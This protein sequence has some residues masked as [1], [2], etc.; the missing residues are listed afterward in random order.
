MAAR[1]KLATTR[2][3]TGGLN[4]RAD[5]FL[6][7]ANESPDLLNVDIDPRGGFR[8]RKGAAAFGS[9][10]SGV[11]RSLWEYT[12]GSIGSQ[13][14][15][16]H[17]GITVLYS[18]GGGWTPVCTMGGTV[19]AATFKDSCYLANG[20]DAFRWDGA[21]ATALG[22]AWNDTEN[23]STGNM[24]RGKCV[25]SHMGLMFVAN[26][27]EAGVA[28]PNRL[29]W[30]MPNFPESYRSYD[31]IDIDIGADG[32]EITALVPWT[33]HLLVFK[34]RAVYALYG[35][36]PETFQ[37]MPVTRELGAVSQE[38][39]V[40]TD[41][42]VYF[43]S[44]PDGVF[45][46]VQGN[47][48]YV[49][50]RIYPAIQDGSIPHSAQAEIMLGWGHRRLWVGVPWRSETRNRSFVLDPAVGKTGAWTTYDL[51]AGP[52]LEYNPPGADSIFL[53]GD[54]ANSQGV[55]R[56]DVDASADDFNGT[57]VP[58]ITRYRTAWMDGGEPALPKRFT[59]PEVILK[60]GND[61]AVFVN[62]YWDW[63]PLDARRQFTLS[64]VAPPD[65]VA[66]PGGDEGTD[67][68]TVGWD[69]SDWDDFSWAEGGASWSDGGGGGAN[70]GYTVPE[71]NELH[72]GRALGKCRAVALEFR[73]PETT[74][75]W[76]VDSITYK[77][78]PR[79]PRS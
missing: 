43:F 15:M 19:R 5:G 3:F 72:R 44:W 16:A 33:D 32:D 2:D 74:Q 49:F 8:Q 58:I 21:T 30:S 22:E 38:A 70:G 56:L 31:Y 9:G 37:V 77:F 71:K 53:A 73:G 17:N 66:D 46:Y 34:K 6:L 26:T 54:S 12:N 40:A 36:S 64:T 55:I 59:R 18:T 28:K 60:S 45:Q 25:A 29:R 23:A 75:D 47:P 52:F 20:L 63:N 67:A 10:F 24:P 13:M 51:A 14:V 39:V 69:L 35:Y 41:I 76:G 65:D 7:A 79:A 42:G 48:S 4:L 1:I 62:V 78:I 27:S 50:E 57:Q 11:P 61:A 68:A